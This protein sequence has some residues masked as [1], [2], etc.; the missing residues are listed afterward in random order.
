MLQ[1]ENS[2][3]YWATFNKYSQGADLPEKHV[4]KSLKW[5]IALLQAFLSLFSNYSQS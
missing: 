5:N 1:Y 2:E 4:R 3:L